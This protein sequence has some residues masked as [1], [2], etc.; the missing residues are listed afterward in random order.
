MGTARSVLLLWILQTVRFGIGQRFQQHEVSHTA[1]IGWTQPSGEIKFDCAGSYL[2][3]NVIMTGAR[4]LERDGAF[5]DVVRLGTAMGAPKDF[6]VH[7][8]S[9][10]YRYQAEYYYHNMAIL[11]LTEDP[12]QVDKHFKPACIY[13][14][15]PP[16]REGKVHL[17][18]RDAGGTYHRTELDLVDSRKCHEFYNP[19]RKLKYGALLVCCMCARNPSVNKCASELGSQMQIVLE[20]NGKKV[21]FLVGQKTI[22]RSCGS[23]IPGIYTRLSS[24]GHLPWIST[25]ARLDF[26]DHDACIKKY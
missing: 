23:M 14:R 6:H 19:T 21:P 11:F 15:P 12:N 10:H 1:L 24:D 20:K 2:G 7:N 9:I 13:S 18:G 25:I 16:I 8:M 22:N 5:T 4:C 17:I 26:H 3:K